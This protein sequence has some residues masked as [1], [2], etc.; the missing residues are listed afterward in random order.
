MATTEGGYLLKFYRAQ[1]HIDA[2]SGALRLWFAEHYSH[3]LEA[4]ADEPN[5]YWL[6]ASA[7]EI[8]ATPFSLMIGDAVQN[9]RNC[10][11]QLA[12]ELAKRHTIPLPDDVARASQF[13]IVG[14]VSKAGVPGQGPTMFASRQG[15]IAGVAPAARVEIEKLQP[16]HS[17]EFEKHP[18]WLLQELS[19]ID[20]HRVIHLTTTYSRGISIDPNLSRNAIPD[21][22]RVRVAGI[23]VTKDSEV[24]RIPIV[25]GKKDREWHVHIEPHP[26]VAFTDGVA[27]DRDVLAVLNE[28][29]NLLFGPVRRALDPFLR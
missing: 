4:D 27:A 29:R 23:A 11:D 21:F 3:R 12:F 6:K 25:M 24:A 22:P 1:E 20:K 28:I 17:K 26:S 9:F 7:D 14:D 10:L 2:L 16:Y 15:C 5:I 8:P 19:N 13:P 18:L